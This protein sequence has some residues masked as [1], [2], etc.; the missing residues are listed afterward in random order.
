MKPCSPAQPGPR[1]VCGSVFAVML[2]LVVHGQVTA[3]LSL[4]GVNLAGGRVLCK[5]HAACSNPRSRA[6]LFCGGL[7]V[8]FARW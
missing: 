5:T 6:F 1:G 8:L 2:V 3:W 4:M 7:N